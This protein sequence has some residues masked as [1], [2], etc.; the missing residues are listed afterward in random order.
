MLIKDFQIKFP[1]GFQKTLTELVFQAG[2]G[3]YDKVVDVVS[4]MFESDES[5]EDITH[6]TKVM[7]SDRNYK[8]LQSSEWLFEPHVS[9][10]LLAH[11]S[12]PPTFLERIQVL[13]QLHQQERD[14]N[15][16]LSL[17]RSRKDRT[18]LLAH[19]KE[20]KQREIKKSSQ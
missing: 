13:Q 7:H 18:I 12:K 20:D 11:T 6:Q 8:P 5:F 4:A 17:K 10:H 3:A 16:Y 14:R 9:T 1:F 2:T 15:T 19:L